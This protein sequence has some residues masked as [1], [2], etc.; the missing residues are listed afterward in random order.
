MRRF[1]APASSRS[2]CCF[3]PAFHPSFL[4]TRSLKQKL[5][6]RNVHPPSFRDGS[7]TALYRWLHLEREDDEDAELQLLFRPRC[8]L[9]FIFEERSNYES[10]SLNPN[11]RLREDVALAPRADPSFGPD[12]IWQAQQCGRN[13]PL[14]CKHFRSE[15]FRS[16]RY[17]C[18][19]LKRLQ[20]VQIRCRKSERRYNF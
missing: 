18:K 5:N 20:G 4:K 12:I 10:P 3:A 19:T 11:V 14:L 2:Q 7:I 16:S 13:M 1:L 8:I 15:R 6:K 9:P 17:V